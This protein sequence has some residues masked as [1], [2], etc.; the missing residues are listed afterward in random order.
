MKDLLDFSESGEDC[1]TVR[2]SF[3]PGIKK[4]NALNV[5]LI[6]TER[7]VNH[8][9]IYCSEA[10]DAGFANAFVASRATHSTV[11]HE[12]SHNLG[13][14]HSAAGLNVM[15]QAIG[16]GA[17]FSEGQTFR[18]NYSSSSAMTIAFGVHTSDKRDCTNTAP[19]RGCPQEE[20]RIWPDP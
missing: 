7:G 20:A 18:M 3:P 16:N 13:L 14:G 17:F 8:R 11:L 4:S 10:R 5:Y 9:G 19:K 6:R 2:T 15:N 1:E 12:L